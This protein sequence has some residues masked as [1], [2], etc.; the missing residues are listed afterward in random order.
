MNLSFPDIYEF[1]V[2]TI[3][4]FLTG[5]ERRRTGMDVQCDYTIIEC[6]NTLQYMRKIYTCLN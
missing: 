5:F 2:V 4:S 3:L 1:L 6:K